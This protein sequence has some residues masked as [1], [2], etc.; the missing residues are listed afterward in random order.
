MNERRQAARQRVEWP[1]TLVFSD[2]GHSLR[3]RGYDLSSGGLGL[4]STD[5]VEPGTACRMKFRVKPRADDFG[6]EMEPWGEVVRVDEQQPGVF[7]VGVEF[8][9]LNAEQAGTIEHYL[10]NLTR[11]AAAAPA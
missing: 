7:R 2:T 8:S 4:L 5:R 6:V 10:R 1:M 11:R 9:M 3:V